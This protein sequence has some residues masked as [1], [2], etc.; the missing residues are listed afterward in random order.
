MRYA[1]FF[2]FAFGSRRLGLGVIG[3]AG[4]F[5]DPVPMPNHELDAAK[6][7]CAMCDRISALARGWR[8]RGYEL[9]LGAGIAAGHATLGRIGFEGRYD[10]GVL[11]SVTNLA[12]RLSDAA[13]PG[14][15]LISQRVYAVLDEQ[16]DT[17][18]VT[19]LQLKGFA[20]PTKAYELLRATRLM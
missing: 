1:R 12:A 10:Y 14:Q 6:L 16:G 13:A 8:K 19:D 7:A 18:P 2:R 5:N 11:G 9:A 4:R 15:I 20:H 3:D 17:K